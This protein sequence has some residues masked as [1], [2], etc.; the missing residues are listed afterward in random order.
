MIFTRHSGENRDPEKDLNSGFRRYGLFARPSRVVGGIIRA[1]FSIVVVCLTLLSAER[2]GCVASE[3]LPA[4]GGTGQRVEA[5]APKA[6]QYDITIVKAYPHDPEAF[7]QGLLFAD[8]SLYESTGAY[9]KNSTLRQVHLE[10]G[11]V[12]RVQ[13]LAREYFGEG[14]TLWQGRLIQLTWR[15]GVG[16]VYD[17]DSFL[18]VG[19][20]H[21]DTE[22]WGI[23]HDGRSL[24]MSDG[25]AVL[26]FLD[27]ESYEEI[28]HIEVIHQGLPIRNLNELEYI[29]G[30]I[31]ANIWGKDTIVR[32]SPEN[33]RVLGWVDLSLL[34]KALGPVQG[35]EAANGIA[36]D[37]VG[38]R[39]FV[40][41]KLWP[42]LFEIKLAPR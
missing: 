9:Q 21:Y 22:G 10:T 12:V 5:Q 27:P 35:A 13:T 17:R 32:V 7:T 34:R 24:I 33:G 26:R 39:I 31:F 16:F 20:F 25:S 23:T 30:E 8:G 42:K 15:S 18:K 36:Y 19:E 40:T 29:Q 6:V 28:R 38:D 37:A 3:P 1:V 4:A 11:K 2:R 41:G 14:L